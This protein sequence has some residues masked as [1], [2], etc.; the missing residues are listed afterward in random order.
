M[1]IVYL[2]Q[3]SDR[4]IAD[5]SRLDI[6]VNN[7]AVCGYPTKQVTQDGFERMF[8]V[9]MLG[10]MGQDAELETSPVNFLR[11]KIKANSG[12][13]SFFENMHPLSSFSG[14]F[15]LTHLLLDKLKESSRPS[16]RARVVN[17]VCGSFD[18][19]A[20]SIAK[21]H[22]KDINYLSRT[23]N[24]QEAYAQSKLGLYLFSQELSKRNDGKLSN[25]LHVTSGSSLCS[26]HSMKRWEISHCMLTVL[27]FISDIDV[28]SVH[29]GHVKTELSR[30]ILANQW[31]VSRILVGTPIRTLYLKR[32]D[33]GMHTTLMCC[34][35]PKLNGTT[36]GFYR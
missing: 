4:L 31:A 21:I 14:P 1:R 17:I 24:R 35:E 11:K 30:H 23:Y 20:Y 18:R 3:V 10:E 25:V 13:E 26:S 12:L 34:V 16:Q 15:L 8:G 33:M 19:E 29:P 27:Y 2:V 32:P 36:G 5:E 6:L 7:A 28:Y 22:F 9:N